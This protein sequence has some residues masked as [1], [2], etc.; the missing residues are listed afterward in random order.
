[1]AFGGTNREPVEPLRPGQRQNRLSGDA[2]V[3]ACGTNSPSGRRYPGAGRV[4]LCA[5]VAA[6]SRSC[7][8]AAAAKLRTAARLSVTKVADR[9]PAI[10]FRVSFDMSPCPDGHP[11]DRSQS[12][13][14]Q[15]ATSARVSSWPLVRFQ[16]EQS[17]SGGKIPIL[18]TTIDIAHKIAESHVARP[19]DCLHLIPK[20]I[21]Q[22]DAG[23]APVEH[24]R[25]FAH[26][27]DHGELNEQS[28]LRHGITPWAVSGS[29]PAPAPEVLAASAAASA[30]LAEGQASVGL[31]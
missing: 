15:C 20:R 19:R 1:M 31:P 13:H 29:E 28:G 4:V 10:R 7:A 30:P 12:D 21:L 3:S 25:A 5:V 22:A 18:S 6:Q 2:C 26:G 23:L 16:N 9:G 11:F 24:D 27:G 17:K 14:R 8:L